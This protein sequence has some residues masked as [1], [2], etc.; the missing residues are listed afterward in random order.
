MKQNAKANTL[1]LSAE[2]KTERKGDATMKPTKKVLNR[3]IKKWKA[4]NIEAA[5]WLNKKQLEGGVESEFKTVSLSRSYKKTGEDTWRSDV[6]HLRRNDI[7]K[8]IMVLQKAQ[9]DLLLTST[10]GDAV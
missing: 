1:I 3:P 4:N 5:V 7:Q 10:G 9:E 8:V 2:T 6:I